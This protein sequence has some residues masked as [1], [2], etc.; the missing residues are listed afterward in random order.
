MSIMLLIF[1]IFCGVDDEAFV[2]SL[3]NGNDKFAISLNP[4]KLDKVHNNGE[5][6]LTEELNITNSV[7]PNVVFNATEYKIDSRTVIK[8]KGID[9]AIVP[10]KK[11]KVILMV[12]YSYKMEDANIYKMNG[13]TFVGS[14]AKVE[15][16]IDGKKE[17]LSVT[18]RTPG[19]LSDISLLEVD[20]K[21]NDATS[22]ALIFTIRNEEYY[23]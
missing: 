2:Y 19:A 17:V 3:F 4:K 23:Y 12:K 9:Y 5:V 7:L 15:A 20:T 8:D 10:L 14:Y 16:E 21:I 18:D 13:K 6:N 22:I 11:D 1:S